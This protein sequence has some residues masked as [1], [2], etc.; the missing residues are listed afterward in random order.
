MSNSF[1]LQGIELWKSLVLWIP[2]MQIKVT[3]DIQRREYKA[4]S[5]HSLFLLE[6]ETLLVL[7][8]AHISLLR[9]HNPELLEKSF[10]GIFRS[11]LDPR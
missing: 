11:L 9:K 7:I 4:I 5:E 10:H 1:P 2:K 3:H 6:F 8:K